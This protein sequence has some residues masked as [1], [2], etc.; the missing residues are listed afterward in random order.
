[1]KNKFDTKRNSRE[2]GLYFRTRGKNEKSTQAGR[3]KADRHAPRHQ[4]LRKGKMKKCPHEI[5]IR[6]PAVAASQTDDG[7][8]KKAEWI[9]FCARDREMKKDRIVCH[10]LCEFRGKK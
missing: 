6:C 8:E 9:I 2:N 3:E 4:G 1:M 7:H 10:D 5:T